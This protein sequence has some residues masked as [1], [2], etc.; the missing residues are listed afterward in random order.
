[1]HFKCGLEWRP[2]KPDENLKKREAKLQSMLNRDSDTTNCAREILALVEK[3]VGIS[4]THNV[5]AE[6][7]RWEREKQQ[8]HNKFSCV[9]WPAEKY[10]TQWI[11]LSVLCSGQ[12]HRMSQWRQRRWQSD[13]IKNVFPFIFAE[14]PHEMI[15]ETRP[16]SVEVFREKNTKFY[17]LSLN[18][19]P[20]C[21]CEPDV[22]SLKSLSIWYVEWCRESFAFFP[23]FWSIGTRVEMKIKYFLCSVLFARL[24]GDGWMGGK[25]RR[26]Q[27]TRNP[28]NSGTVNDDSR[29]REATHWHFYRCM[30]FM[31]KCI[32]I[33]LMP[34]FQP[35]HLIHLLP[36]QKTWRRFWR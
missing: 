13:L 4:H 9:I 20:I 8:Q 3:T 32:N 10:F 11:T 35:P 1:M 6:R 36:G 5:G 23:S 7:A 12:Q 24:R 26:E 22:F 29:Q 18:E 30:I 16:S 33:R 15:S 25:K 21:L 17:F 14:F 19:S 2:Q 31:R 34:W 27:S 28:Y